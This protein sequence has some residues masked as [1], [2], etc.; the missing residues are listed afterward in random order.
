[1]RLVDLAQ[2]D[3]VDLD[4]ARLDRIE[5][6]QQLGQRGL[7]GTGAPDDADGRTDRNFKVEVLDDL[8]RVGP[9]LKGHVL[10]GDVSLQRV[11]DAAA[12]RLDRSVH[13]DAEHAHRK[14]DLLVLVNQADPV[15]RPDSIW[16][17][18]RAPMLISCL[19]TSIAPSQMTATVISISSA[20]LIVR[21]VIE[22]LPTRK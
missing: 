14:R 15:T 13:D 21:A 11:A 18:I 9:V 1:M 12:G 2:V 8:R 17:A 20:W 4:Q 10:K 6:L 5:S 19:K 22:I 7:A 16:N 3:A